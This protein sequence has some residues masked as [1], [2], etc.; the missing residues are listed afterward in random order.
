MDLASSRPESAPRPAS[1]FAVPDRRCGDPDR[2]VI[3]EFPRSLL[4]TQS[5]GRMIRAHILG[6]GVDGP[7]QCRAK[8]PKTV[9]Q[10][11]PWVARTAYASN[12]RARCRL[13]CIAL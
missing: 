2:E 10:V 5:A 11:Q 1:V 6:L 4:P 13:R 8:S 7:F 9:P 3:G 12:Q